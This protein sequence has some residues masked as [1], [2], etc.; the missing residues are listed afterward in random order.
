VG[1]PNAADNHLTLNTTAV[2][3]A[4]FRDSS[5]LAIFTDFESGGTTNRSSTSP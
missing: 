5:V 4:D 1:Q 3:I 2:T